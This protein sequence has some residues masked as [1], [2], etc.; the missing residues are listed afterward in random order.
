MLARDSQKAAQTANCSNNNDPQ[1]ER[2]E[3]QQQ[4]RPD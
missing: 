2:K 3:T 1:R 4:Y